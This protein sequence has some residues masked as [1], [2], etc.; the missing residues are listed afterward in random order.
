MSLRQL[1]ATLNTAGTIAAPKTA[2]YTATPEDCVIY[3][4]P[5][6][7]GAFTVTL[8]SRAFLEPGKFYI[9]VNVT[10]S[11]NAITIATEGSET[12]NGAA[13]VSVNASREWVIVLCDGTNANAV[14]LAIPA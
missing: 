3:C 11:T 6:S 1:F 2:A 9:I 8:P 10:T 14:Q 5:A 4:D 7:V 12:I 13:S